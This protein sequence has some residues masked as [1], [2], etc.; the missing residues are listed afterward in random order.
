MRQVPSDMAAAQ[1]HERRKSPYT[2]STSKP[3]SNELFR[4]EDVRLKWSS[5]RRAVRTAVWS[6]RMPQ[7]LSFL[8]TSG[9]ERFAWQQ[10]HYKPGTS[11][12]TC[13]SNNPL[14]LIVMEYQPLAS[15]RHS[16]RARDDEARCIHSLLSA[17]FHPLNNVH[18]LLAGG[19]WRRGQGCRTWAT[20]AS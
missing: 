12:S 2:A 5:V 15:A 1:Q 17:T 18:Q 9:N 16:R 8:A 7:M 11:S 14:T 10:Q 6:L 13:K 19:C 3:G 20:R 4:A